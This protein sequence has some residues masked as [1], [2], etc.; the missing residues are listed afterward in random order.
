MS[1]P[2]QK[3]FWRKLNKVNW[4]HDWRLCAVLET[5]HRR[6]FKSYEQG[7]VCKVACQISICLIFF[8]DRA[9]TCYATSST[10]LVTKAG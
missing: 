3:R 7:N 2:L 6:F 1:Q 9:K 10:K 4:S 8:L 5:D